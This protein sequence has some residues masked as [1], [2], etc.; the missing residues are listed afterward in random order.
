MSKNRDMVSRVRSTH[1]LL[2]DASIT[3][4]AIYAELSSMSRTLIKQQTDKRKLWATSTIF[5]T[6]PCLEMVEVPLA[7]CCDYVSDMTIARSKHRLPK[8][9]EG[10]YGLLIQGVFSVDGGKKL[11]ESTSARFANTMKL[12]LKNVPTYYWVQDGFI[13]VSSSDVKLIKVI[14]Y[15]EE[16][17]PE[18]VINPQCNCFAA[19]K[20]DA[21][22]NPLD[23]EFKCPGTLETA[24][25]TAVSNF[26]LQTYF[27]VPTDQSSDSKDDQ[28]NKN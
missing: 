27:R 5:T 18:D 3:D 28:V 24:V 4:R 9:G 13:Y 22:M 1:K 10:N 14:A 19:R 16:D 25:V 23:R 6:I 26:L 11:N 17:V 8:I 2:G 7:E 15:F 12:G 20:E 21:C